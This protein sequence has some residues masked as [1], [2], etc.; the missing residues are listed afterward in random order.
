MAKTAKSAR[1][2]RLKPFIPAS[3]QWR[4]ISVDAELDDRWLTGVNDAVAKL[5]GRVCSMCT[6]HPEGQTNMGGDSYPGFV[7]RFDLGCGHDLE[8]KAEAL[9][10]KL[11][12]FNTEVKTTWW[13]DEFG[14]TVTHSNGKARKAELGRCWKEIAKHDTKTTMVEANCIIAN[15]GNNQDELA[16]WWEA[17]V[18]RLP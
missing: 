17:V 12:G 14:C 7:I 10:S 6:G 18:S 2:T 4:G 1:K 5:G 15:S 9:A 16:K 11:R 3:R 8:R 13:G